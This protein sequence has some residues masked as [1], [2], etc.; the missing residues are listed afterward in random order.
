MVSNYDFLWSDV[1]PHRTIESNINALIRYDDNLWNKLKNIFHFS[2]NNNISCFHSKEDLEQD[3]LRGNCFLNGE[4]VQQFLLDLK[5]VVKE[6]WKIFEEVKNT[7]INALSDQEIT[8]LFSKVM[9]NG[10]E[11]SIGY[12][13]ASQAE[14]THYLLE[15]LKESFSEEEISILLTPLEIDLA[16]RELLDWEIL[17]KNEFSEEKLIEHTHKYPWIVMSHSTMEEVIETLTQRFNYDQNNSNFKDL[18][19]E[20]EGL[21]QK[22]ESI[23]SKHPEVKE[24]VEILHNFAIARME[25]KSC[26]GGS[27]FYLIPIIKEISNRTGENSHDVNML[28][29]MKEVKSLLLDHKKL[30]DEEKERRKE[31][32]VGIFK[33]GKVSYFSGEDAEEVTKEELQELYM[34][35]NLNELK[36]FAANPGKIVGKARIL[37]ANNLEQTR[38]LRTDFNKGE[39]LITQMTQPSV[40]DIA[41]RAAALITDEG[42]MLSH[43][44]IISREFK[45]PCIVGTKIATQIFKDGDLVE[46]DADKGIVKKIM[47]L[48]TTEQCMELFDRYK[49]PTNIK[50]H[51]LHVNKLAMFLAKKLKEN[52]INLNLELVNSASLLHDLFKAVNIDLLKQSEHHPYTPSD[53]EIQMWKKLKLQFPDMEET[54]VAYQVFKEEYP[55]LA[56]VLRDSSDYNNENKTWEEH[57]IIYSDARTLKNKVVTLSERFNYL[58]KVYPH[59]KDKFDICGLELK[60]FE[61]KIT[62]LIKIDPGNIALEMK[63]GR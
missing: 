30:S 20:K 1:Q 36:G 58:M 24:I 61:Q 48:P 53:E 56:N 38:K 46:V 25:I 3:Q 16:G 45:I 51:C 9:K 13:R 37:Q 7:K 17:V 4:Y 59:K 26:W 28:Y 43:A 62:Q 29:L 40:M 47:N 22:Q 18:I 44:A 8:E 27:D 10:W 32:F 49:V 6:N 41:S 33:D 23:L 11:K 55:Q 34:Y 5:N 39:I 54:E 14:G 12:F 35:E 31:M 60:N 42:G 19:K 63:N 52:N 21:K 50:E 15:K 2:K 57:L